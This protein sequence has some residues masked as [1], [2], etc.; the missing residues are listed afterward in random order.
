MAVGFEVSKGLID[1]RS[2]EAGR[3]LLRAFELA[4]TLKVWLDDHP[5]Y[6]AV[7]A[8]VT[9][10]GYTED[11]AYLLHSVFTEMDALRT[12]HDGAFANLRKLTGLE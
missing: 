1:M 3:A 11:E 10:Y 4:R 2:G 9:E 12:A 6:D 5:G 7:S 8:L